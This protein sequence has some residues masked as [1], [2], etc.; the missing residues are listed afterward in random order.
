MTV[1]ASPNWL[2]DRAQPGGPNH[3]S[4]IGLAQASG[5]AIRRANDALI[6]ATL[7]RVLS[8]SH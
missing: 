3:G 8:G 2:D 5:F 4:E 1:D 7:E 6:P